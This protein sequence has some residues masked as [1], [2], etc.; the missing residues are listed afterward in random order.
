MIWSN[1]IRK[2]GIDGSTAVICTVYNNSIW[3]ANLG[4][5]RAMLFRNSS[6]FPLTEDHT[7]EGI[8]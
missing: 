1:L 6:S 7:P 4:D 5:S 3:S 2:P 8:S